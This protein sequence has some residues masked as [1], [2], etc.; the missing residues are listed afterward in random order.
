MRD[1]A[2][3]GI[4]FSRRKL[5]QEQ[6]TYLAELPPV[7]DVGECELVHASLKNPQ[8]WLYVMHG[9]DAEEHFEAQTQPFCFCGH[10]H[11]PRVWHQNKEGKITA[12]RGTGRIKL[13]D[14]GKALINVGSVGQPRDLCPDACYVLFNPASREV[15]FRRVP[16]DIQKARRKIIRAKLPRYSAQRLSLGR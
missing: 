9:R 14:D 8:E 16:Y 6:R 3:S 12:W 4:E 2:R 7:V 11:V 13:P 10:T 5:S 15:E 1:V